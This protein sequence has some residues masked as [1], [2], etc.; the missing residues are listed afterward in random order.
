MVATSDCPSPLR[1]RACFVALAIAE[2]SP[3]SGKHVLLVADSVT[4]LAMAQ[5]DI[6]LSAGEPPSQKATPPVFRFCPGSSSAPGTSGIMG[7]F[8][9]L[10]EGDD[11]NE[12]IATRCAEFWTATLCSPA[13]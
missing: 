2:H 5:R 8:T 11:M 1:V 4:R 9:V 7:F 13:P 10:V 6:G 12:P 3:T